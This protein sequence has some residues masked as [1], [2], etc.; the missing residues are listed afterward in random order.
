MAKLWKSDTIRNQYF[1][2]SSYAQSLYKNLDEA[3]VVACILACI[4]EDT[5][6]CSSFSSLFSNTR[7]V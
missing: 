5:S 4:D 7:L 3:K 2:K 6:T 1:L